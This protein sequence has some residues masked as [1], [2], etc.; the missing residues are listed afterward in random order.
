V[1]FAKTK[2]RTEVQEREDHLPN[3]EGRQNES[4]PANASK[5]LL[6]D[7]QQIKVN[8]KRGV[9]ENGIKI[10]SRLL[11][12]PFGMSCSVQCTEKIEFTEK[13]TVSARN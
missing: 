2:E 6:L 11:W 5:W 9:S 3:I 7:S 13:E 12:M 8:L 1:P 4:V 10:D